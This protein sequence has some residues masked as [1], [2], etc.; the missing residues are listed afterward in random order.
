MSHSASQQDRVSPETEELA[1]SVAR[2][3]LVGETSFQQIFAGS[4]GSRLA[5]ALLLV[6]ARL[7]EL[8]NHRQRAEVA[9]TIGPVEIPRVFRAS[10]QRERS[11]LTECEV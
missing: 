8:P 2:Q 3:L 7:Q 6:P 11:R 1:Q 10:E 4:V 9:R 5:K